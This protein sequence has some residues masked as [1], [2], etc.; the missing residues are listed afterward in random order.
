MRDRDREI[1]YAEVPE[2][3]ARMPHGA[4]LPTRLPF[5]TVLIQGAVALTLPDTPPPWQG[6][7]WGDSPRSWGPKG[8][9][10]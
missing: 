7:N 4:F 1:D 9:G 6:G 3:G 10:R 5:S 8:Y 2:A